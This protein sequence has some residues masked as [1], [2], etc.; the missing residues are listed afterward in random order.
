M[1]TVTVASGKGG[2]GKTTL[3]ALFALT[4][5]RSQTVVLADAD[6]EAS[7][8]PIALDSKELECEAF[9]GGLRVELDPVR[10]TDCGSCADVCRFG[11]VI[12]PVEGGKRVRH[13][14]DQWICEGCGACIAVCPNKALRAVEV[15]AGSA[16]TGVSR[17]GPIAYGQL[18]PGE[19]LSGRLVTEVRERAVRAA[20]DI[21][22][23]LILIDGPPGI[24][25]PVIAAIT[26][27]DLLVAVTEPTKSGLHDLNRLAELASRLG[28]PITV[29]LNK[30]DLSSEG[31][32]L[33]RDACRERDLELIAEVPF[34]EVLA[35]TLSRIA[36]GEDPS[37]TSPGTQAAFEAW[38]RITEHRIP[39]AR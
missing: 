11:A 22:A 5:A 19:D 26:N 36:D 34:D 32:D 9:T 7:N 20:E 30:A 18:G 33:I 13:A 15:R 12:A 31:A 2:T 1:I 4:A 14:V 38:K 39:S 17:V 28:L 10:C 24:G 8:L 35:E 37:A 21:A 3:T 23:D 27:T 16:C 25:C 6:V 29:V